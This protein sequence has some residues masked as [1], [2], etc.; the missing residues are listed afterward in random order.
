MQQVPVSQTVSYPIENTLNGRG[1]VLQT[2]V[3][4]LKRTVTREDINFQHPRMTI[5]CVASIYSAYYKTVEITSTL[6]P[7]RKL[8]R[9]REEA[10]TETA[11]QDPHDKGIRTRVYFRF[12][13]LDFQFKST[14]NRLSLK[15]LSFIYLCELDC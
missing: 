11:D 9:R 4:G 12:V 6:K 14:I 10:V 15:L 1:E 13:K 2:A 5:K 8:K 7:K 3:L